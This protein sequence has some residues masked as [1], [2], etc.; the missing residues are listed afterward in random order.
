[1]GN[2]DY[3]QGGQMSGA[4]KGVSDVMKTGQDNQKGLI[5]VIALAALAVSAQAIKA[6]TGK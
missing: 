6:I 4:A 5:G 3:K 1:M 2:I